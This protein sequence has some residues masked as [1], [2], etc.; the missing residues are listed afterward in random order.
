M[1]SGVT[2]EATFPKNFPLIGNVA[3]RLM[4][5]SMVVMLKSTLNAE[6]V[7]LFSVLFCYPS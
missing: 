1:T 3:T 4:L 5:S 2:D 7:V 6:K